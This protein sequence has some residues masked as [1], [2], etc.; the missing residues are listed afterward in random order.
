MQGSCKPLAT[1]TLASERLVL[2]CT[3]L[4]LL[5]FCPDS[6]VEGSPLVWLDWGWMDVRSFPIW[7]HHNMD[8]WGGRKMKSQRKGL[9]F[10]VS[11]GCRR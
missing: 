11:Q 3:G 1:N 10:Q 8:L 5:H 2:L 7:N 4:G 6:R 9:R